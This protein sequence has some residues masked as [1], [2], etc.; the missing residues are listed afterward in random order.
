MGAELEAC[1]TF[2]RYNPADSDLHRGCETL[3]CQ[4]ISKQ[5]RNKA[6][7]TAMPKSSQ[8]ATPLIVAKSDIFDI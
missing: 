2:G 8:D 1:Q 3:N 4:R 7:T 6:P 5:Q